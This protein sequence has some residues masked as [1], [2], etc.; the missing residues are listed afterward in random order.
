MLRSWLPLLSNNIYIIKNPFEKGMMDAYITIRKKYEI[1]EDY[2][3]TSL[4]LSKN[5]DLNVL[6]EISGFLGGG[7]N[8]KFFDG[9][10]KIITYE[11][12][13]DYMREDQGFVIRIKCMGEDVNTQSNSDLI[14]TN[15]VYE[16]IKNKVKTTDVMSMKILNGKRFDPHGMEKFVIKSRTIKLNFEDTFESTNS[17][18]RFV[19]RYEKNPELLKNSYLSSWLEHYKSEFKDEVKH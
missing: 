2:S 4:G 16:F 15:E 14:C 18:K 19:K 11:N 9:D 5:F 12:V 6:F 10:L 8:S 17:L 1:D 13:K 7:E 3:I